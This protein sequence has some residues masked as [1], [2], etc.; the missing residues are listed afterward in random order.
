[1]G[2]KYNVKKKLRIV[3][4]AVDNGIIVSYLNQKY[5]GMNIYEWIKWNVKNRI[6]T[7]NDNERELIEKLT[8]KALSNFYEY[9][10]PIL[11]MDIIENKEIGRYDSQLKASKEI[12]KIYGYKTTVTSIRNCANN[13]Q[14]S[15]YKG[16]FMFY[17]VTDEEA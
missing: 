2:K 10:K 8:G 12:Q 9:N 4:D 11:V 1:M 3:K 6:D 15:P 16:R 17:Y 13:I 7:L 14:K 5:K